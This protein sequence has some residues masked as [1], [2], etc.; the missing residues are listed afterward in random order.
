MRKLGVAGHHHAL[1]IVSSDP[2]VRY[3]HVASPCGVLIEMRRG[4]VCW[5][6]PWLR[7]GNGSGQPVFL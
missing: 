5:F 6:D 2:S 7:H 1:L 4:T 3:V